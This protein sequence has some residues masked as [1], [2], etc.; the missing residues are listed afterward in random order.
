[1]MSYFHASGYYSLWSLHELYEPWHQHAAMLHVCLWSSTWFCLFL[2]QVSSVLAIYEGKSEGRCR[3][4]ELIHEIRRPHQVF[5]L[6]RVWCA[7]H[8]SNI[9]TLSVMILTWTSSINIFTDEVS[10]LGP[11][12]HSLYLPWRGLG[13]R[14]SSQREQTKPMWEFA[15]GSVR[16]RKI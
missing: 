14:V 13:G 7:L 8:E 5:K 16:K 12:I 2:S 15:K 11:K 9:S 10:G 6:Q 1:M 4:F 3:Q